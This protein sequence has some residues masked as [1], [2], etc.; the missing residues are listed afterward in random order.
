MHHDRKSESFHVVVS[1]MRFMS[2]PQLARMRSRSPRYRRLLPSITPSIRNVGAFAMPSADHGPFAALLKTV[3][4]ALPQPAPP[5]CLI[6][7]LAVSAWGYVRSTRDIDLLVLSDEPAR[8]QLVEG[9]VARGFQRDSE[10][11]ERNPLAKDVVL[12]LFHRSHADYPLDLLFAG[13]AHSQ[14]TLVR[15]RAV[16]VLGISLFVCSPEDLIILKMKAGRPHDF[17]DALGIVKNHDLRLDFAYLKSWATRLGLSE[18]LQYILNA[19]QS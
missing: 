9:L 4:E 13:D 11:M 6:G 16:H 7:A 18:E 14:S 3:I 19:A 2:G 1:P 15:R 8:S 12:R 5:Y 10:W 17:E